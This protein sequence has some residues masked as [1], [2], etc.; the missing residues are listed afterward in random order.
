MGQRHA[1]ATGQP[2]PR[3]TRAKA[4]ELASNASIRNAFRIAENLDDWALQ[5]LIELTEIPAPP[6]M[7]EARGRR[8][9]ELL[10]KHGA[11]SV[12]TDAEGNVIGLRRGPRRRPHHR[13]RRPPRH[14]LPRGH[15]RDR[16]P[17]RRHAP[18]ARRRRRHPRP[19]G[20]AGGAPRHARGRHPDG[21]RR[22]LRWRGRRGGPGRPA[23]HEAHVPRSGRGP[24]RLDR[25][26]W[27]RTGKARDRRSGFGALPHH[28]PGVPGDTPGAPSDTPTPRTR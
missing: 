14:R 17:A 13:I 27:R 7:E 1:A 24:R 6:F 25:G 28:L 18:R 16:A 9:A 19:R 11:D 2:P 4:N 12:W 26:G 20:R 23:R 8:F 22:A 15:R 3:S 10:M 21:R 5:L